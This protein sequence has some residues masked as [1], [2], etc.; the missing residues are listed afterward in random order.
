MALKFGQS[1]IN[2]LIEDCVRP[3]VEQRTGFKLRVLTEPQP[4]G[5]IDD[6]I[7]SGILSARFAIADLTDGS[8]GAYWEAGFAEGVGIPVIYSC[9][10]SV[11][12]QEKT[13]FDTNHMN[14]VLW[15]PDKLKEAQDRLVGIIRV[16]PALRADAKQTDE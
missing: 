16:T 9:K 11:W 4:A 14:T 2:T 15:E 7:R 12:D 1:E 8:R 5:L 10:K 6:Q 13:H 3:A